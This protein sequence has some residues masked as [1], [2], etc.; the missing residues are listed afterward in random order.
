MYIRRY[1]L[2]IWLL[3]IKLPQ[4]PVC[5]SADFVDTGHGFWIPVINFSDISS[6]FQWYQRSI[7]VK[8]VIAF[9]DTSYQF[10]MEKEQVW[11]LKSKIKKNTIAFNVLVQVICGTPA[12]I[13]LIPRIAGPEGLP[14]C[15]ASA[16]AGR[17]ATQSYRSMDAT[18]LD[19]KIVWQNRNKQKYVS[20]PM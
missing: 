1:Q 13:H 19:H 5:C 10:R 11:G 2:S 4:E 15:P 12:S 7:L 16:R 18:D 9:G 6:Q 17:I 14:P 3:E 8:P 20:I